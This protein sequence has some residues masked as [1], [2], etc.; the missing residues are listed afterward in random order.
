MDY[1]KFRMLSLVFRQEDPW[2]S[3]PEEHCPG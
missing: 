3:Q 2:E 1:Y